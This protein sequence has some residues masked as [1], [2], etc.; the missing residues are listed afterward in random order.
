MSEYPFSWVTS[1]C[2]YSAV[3]QLSASKG[4]GHYPLW[5][6]PRSPFKVPNSATPP[7]V[8][9]L[10]KNEKKANTPTNPHL[11]SW[12]CCNKVHVLVYM[13]FIQKSLLQ[14]SHCS[15]YLM[16]I[17][18]STYQQSRSSPEM[19]DNIFPK[20]G[21]QKVGN[22]NCLHGKVETEN[23]CKASTSVQHWKCSLFPY[24]QESLLLSKAMS[25]E[26]L[27]RQS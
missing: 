4:L 9:Y 12:S 20:A 21:G 26:G 11:S 17:S 24:H 14:P 2:W 15:L 6:L 27:C 19:W 25:L 13:D 1:S 8:Q 3:P 10:I 18:W 5:T 23:L 16:S 22:D 7:P